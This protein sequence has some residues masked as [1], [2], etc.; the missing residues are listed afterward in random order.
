MSNE[1][2]SAWVMTT[3]G[4]VCEFFAGYAFP[5]EMQ[6]DTSQELP[7]YKVR[8]ISVAWNLNSKV[9]VATGN[10]LSHE[11]AKSIK[12]Y[13]IP[14]GTIIFAKIGE[15]LR[16]NRRAILPKPALIDNNVMGILGYVNAVDQN[17]LY[18]FTTVTR[19]DADA[20]AS[21]VPSIRKSDV[22]DIAFPLP[23]FKEQSRI[24]EKLE[25]LFSDL[26]AGVAELKAAQKKLAQYRQSLLKAAVK[27]EL[28]AEWRTKNT[29]KETGAQLLERILK[30]RRARWEEKQLARFKE[31]GKTPPKG[32]QDKYPEPVQPDTTNLLELPEGWVWASVEQ[33][34]EV[35][36]GK[37]LDK[38]KHQTGAML[39]YLRNISV[40][41][42][43]I[44]THDL[45]EMYYEEDELERY[46][47][48][49]GD[50]LVCEGGEPGRAAVCGKEH[51][52]LKYQKALHRVRLFSLYESDLLVFYLEHL[53]KTG[54]LE[55]YFTGSTIKHFTKESFIAL[56]IPLPPICEQLEIVEHLKLAIQCAQEQDAAII[57]SLTQAAAQRK[58]IL[59]SAFSG[60]LVLQ[61]PNDEP[62]SLLLERIRAERQKQAATLT[63]GRKKVNP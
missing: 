33:V 32:W 41:W 47:L 35:F 57:H 16:L 15:A 63:R 60:Q 48:A 5:K 2:P 4:D 37:M 31:Q 34:G 25:E 26:D 50:V 13:P 46:G 52:K 62:A 9:C 40:R 27:G 53:A 17:Y 24:V 10:S 3:L 43:S 44:E 30:E 1:I 19:F 22:A 18:W 38:T 20:R 59:K 6:G 7:F 49:S 54:M 29:P 45:P 42:G 58:N 8:D 28:T 11:L 51:E 56:P 39:P 12:A 36:L 14:T 23:P 55:Q 61:D 21:V